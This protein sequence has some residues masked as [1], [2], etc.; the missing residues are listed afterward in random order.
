MPYPRFAS[1]SHP[2]DSWIQLHPRIVSI[3]HNKYTVFFLNSESDFPAHFRN[4][5]QYIISLI[6]HL[7]FEVKKK[8]KENSRLLPILSFNKYDL[9]KGLV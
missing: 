1:V 2:F 4:N 8:I 5:P 9:S 6:E 3:D 7:T